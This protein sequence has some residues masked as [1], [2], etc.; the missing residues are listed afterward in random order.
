MEVL[1]DGG[2]VQLH[3]AVHVLERT[4][5]QQPHDEV[6]EDLRRD[7]LDEAVAAIL[8]PSAHDVEWTA[9]ERREHRLEARRVV[10]E[11]GVE[12]EDVLAGGHLK[13]TREGRR[14]AEISPERVNP[15][16]AVACR[17]RLQ[18][19]Q[20]SIRRS[21][22]HCDD[23]IRMSEPGHRLVDAGEQL[24]KALGLVVNRDDD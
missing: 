23:F 2:A 14:L 22:V 16:A 10:L 3:A 4:A 6:I 21:I 8:P 17:Q 19:L 20:G 15:D 1:C 11:V 5:E 9:C 12:R 24:A 7:D 18:R 13:S